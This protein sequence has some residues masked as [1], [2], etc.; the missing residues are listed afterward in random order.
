MQRLAGAPRR[1]VVALPLAAGVLGAVIV[2]A[3]PSAG[4]QAPSFVGHEVRA[5][6]A[7]RPPAGL[8]PALQLSYDLD[9]GYLRRQLR[10][11]RLFVGAH[12]LGLEVTGMPLPR[13]ERPGDGGEAGNEVGEGTVTGAR[14]GL[15]VEPFGPARLA[16]RLTFAG[17][18]SRVSSDLP[19]RQDV[20]GTR[21]GLI[22]GAGLRLGLD[23]RQGWS[24]LLDA[25]HLFMDGADHWSFTL[26]LRYTPLGR[27]AYAP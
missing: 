26:G 21:W 18:V 1:S 9:L 27:L 12:R 17:T 15:R 11:L 19:D 10:P 3:T 23:P 16:P 2:L 8:W 22:V 25:K 24:A 6:V 5:G 4:Q 7:D 13:T 14:A 20:D